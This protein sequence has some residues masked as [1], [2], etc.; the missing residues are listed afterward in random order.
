MSDKS[1]D[2]LVAALPTP[3]RKRDFY[4]AWLALAFWHSWS[5]QDSIAGLVGLL[6]PII[7]RFIPTWGSAMANLAWQIPLTVLFTLF[8]ARLALAPYWLYSERDR[9]SNSGELALKREIQEVR[10]QLSDKV[11]QLG[12]RLNADGFL[13]RLGDLLAEANCLLDKLVTTR[14]LEPVETQAA[15][16]RERTIRYLAQNRPALRVRFTSK[17]KVVYPGTATART[18]ALANMIYTGIV[19]LDEIVKELSND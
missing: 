2:R 10:R 17:P 8:V 4:R 15:D 3:P 5:K 18:R 11:D 12:E 9:Q 6:F 19:C 14:T 1:V 13:A 16:W 7:A